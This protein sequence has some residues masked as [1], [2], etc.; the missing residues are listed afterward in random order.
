[1][2]HSAAPTLVVLQDLRAKLQL[3]SDGDGQQLLRLQ[4][5]NT[6]LRRELAAKDHAIAERDQQLQAAN[7][8]RLQQQAMTQ[9]MPGTQGHVV[10]LEQCRIGLVSTERMSNGPPALS[11][12]TLSFCVANCTAGVPTTVELNV[13][14]PGSLPG[15]PVSLALAAAGANGISM[16]IG[17]AAVPASLPVPTLMNVPSAGQQQLV[18]TSAPSGTIATQLAPATTLPG[19]AAPQVT[20]AQALPTLPV[21]EAAAVAAQQQVQMLAGVQ[22]AQVVVS[23]PAPS[24]PAV[25]QMLVHSTSGGLQPAM[26]PQVAQ[27]TATTLSGGALAAAAAKPALTSVS[28]ALSGEAGA[29]TA[30]VAA[31]GMHPSLVPPVATTQ[32][33]LTAPSDTGAALPAPAAAVA[34]QAAQNLNQQAQQLAVHATLHGQAKS[35][36][37]TQAQQLASQAQLHAQASVQAAVQA[38]QLKQTIA[39]ETAPCLVRVATHAHLASCQH[40]SSTS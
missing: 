36:A 39:G 30:A 7:A 5:D 25:Q 10:T 33:Q 38:E 21:P 2:S 32:P 28:E 35:Q 34:D 14:R 29:V 22:P 37:T 4:D 15:G 23:M 40:L 11:N 1:M 9:G 16:P 13:P 24:A 19:L 3:L 17:T 12:L 20:A 27:P 26:V 31:A 18:V 8:A 6:Q